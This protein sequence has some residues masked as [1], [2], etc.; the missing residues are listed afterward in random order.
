MVS[1][2]V[3]V[4]FLVVSF[5]VVVS[6]LVVVVFLVVSSSVVVSSVVVSS[7]VVSN[8]E[9]V[10]SIGR[11]VVT[12]VVVSVTVVVSSSLPFNSLGKKIAIITITTSTAA[13]ITIILTSVLLPPLGVPPSEG[14][15]PP[16]SLRTES[17]K[18][19]LL[20][21]IKNPFACYKKFLTFNSRCFN[22][23]GY[24]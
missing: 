1:F 20:S 13:R 19:L 11:V 6:F 5:S 8:G 21:M 17:R 22:M 3:V 16:I 10:V 18:S 7:V 2:L 9:V 12:S 4:V 24:F 23:Q 14:L 15:F